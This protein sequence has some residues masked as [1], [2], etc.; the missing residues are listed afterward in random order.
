M[1]KIVSYNLL[2]PYHAEK[3]KTP[4][5]IGLDE[6][7]NWDVDG[8]P[9]RE[10]IFKNILNSE[11]DVACLQEV[12]PIV[13][14]ELKEWFS[15][16]KIEV[17]ELSLCRSAPQEEDKQKLG[18]TILYNPEKLEYLSHRVFSSLGQSE[19]PRGEIFADFR[20]RSDPKVIIRV[21]STH[22]KGYDPTMYNKE[23][24]AEEYKRKQIQ[25]IDGF[26]EIQDVVNE[27]LKDLSQEHTA[28]AICGDFN[29][30]RDV[31]L[32]EPNS[33][34]EHM[35]NLGF[36]TDGNGAASEARTGRKIDW[37]YVKKNSNH[38]T[39]ELEPGNP[40]EQDL[41][42]SDHHLISTIVNIA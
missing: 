28:V 7:S 22:L 1:V 34:H 19:W 16:H 40:G 3:W 23:E 41:K 31:E 36:N 32:A 29:C 33:R 42:A 11:C 5:G 30:H 6:K 37:I 8:E 35:L 2:N 13:H 20:L 12:N 24:K 14:K 4:E 15:K 17:L 9:R 27:T 21:A 39:I 18:V 25:K 38:R 10:R 26:K